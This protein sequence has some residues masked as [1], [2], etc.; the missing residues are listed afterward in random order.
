MKRAAAESDSLEAT[1]ELLAD[2]AAIR[3]IRQAEEEFASGEFTTM[4]EMARF[5]AKR[6]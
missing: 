1:M 2:E 3:R 6:R 5:M 4:E